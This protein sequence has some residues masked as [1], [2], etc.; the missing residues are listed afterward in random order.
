MLQKPSLLLLTVL[1]L[2]PRFASASSYGLILSGSGACTGCNAIP[3]INEQDAITSFSSNFSESGTAG[4]LAALS[5]SID[6]GFLHGYTKAATGTLFDANANAGLDAY[7]YDTFYITG[8]AGTSGIF[9]ITLNFDGSS[10]ATGSPAIGTYVDTYNLLENGTV[11][12]GIQY[13]GIVSTLG[14]PF[15]SGSNQLSKTVNLTLTAGTTVVLGELLQMR[16]QMINEG[17]PGSIT[18]D[19]SDTGYMLVTP[20]TSGVGF[21]T[22]SGF[23]YNTAPSPVPEPGS[24]TLFWVVLAAGLVV[25]TYRGSSGVSGSMWSRLASLRGRSLSR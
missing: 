15:N 2:L 14:I 13:L 23:L 6:Y 1:C 10:T 19:N 20:M 4:S 9:Q 3:Q 21:T 8:A 11:I 12:P 22:A 16:E 5:A 18:I 25:S 7:F 17:S 24:A